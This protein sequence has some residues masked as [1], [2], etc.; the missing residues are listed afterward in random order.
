M[1]KRIF[2]KLILTLIGLFIVAALGVDYFVTRMAETN[3]RRGLE[4]GL[5]EQARLAV[6]VLR[7][8]PAESSPEVVGE[9]AEAAGARLTLIRSDGAVVADSE[10]DPAT[11]ENHATR[12]EFAAALAGGVGISARFSSTVGTEFLYVA[13]P[14][15]DG[16]LRLALPLSEIRTQTREIRGRIL[17]V[18]LLAFMP[19]VFLA[20]WLAQ[21]L[22]ARLSQIMSFSRDLA[23]GDFQA[24]VPAFSGGE[25]GELSL[26]LQTTADR[27][28][29]MFEQLQEERS[30]FAAAVNGIGAGVLVMDRERRTIV[31]NP[32]MRRMFPNENLGVGDRPFTA[33]HRDIARLF[34]G[35]F[36]QGTSDSVDLSVSEPVKRTWKVSCAPIGGAAGQAQAAVAVFYDITELEETERV[37][38]D[39]VTNVSHELRTPLA[40]IQ[41]YAETLLD[42]AV[43]DPE[44]NRRFLQIIRQNAERLAQ[45][46]S[47]LMALSQIEIRA[48]N[49]DFAPVAVNNLLTQ[50]SDSIRTLTDKKGVAVR[51]E[52]LPVSTEVE[53]D[54][55]S[56]HQV[57]MNLLENAANY[58]PQ[59]GAITLGARREDDEVEFYVRD[60]GVGV[61]SQ[62]IPR[63]FERFYRVDKARSRELGGTG[64]GLA[65]VKHL[66]LAHEG[67][68]RVESEVGR[69]STFYVRIPLQRSRRAVAMDAVSGAVD[70]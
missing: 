26:T 45:L 70:K 63:L 47:D 51:V 60:S 41:G 32:A 67:S 37:R 33:S 22:S 40:S 5:K 9:I 49:Y 54:S 48:R 6:A 53:C 21:R 20:F 64:L 34:D 12:P 23:R 19:A 57:L 4:D 55:D 24:P 62:H 16:A 10:A 30:R 38:R 28:R 29:S 65:I 11:M 18:T 31:C 43:D 35:V 50:A 66:V 1:T 68:V 3:L 2:L 8:R 14:S 61:A 58:T 13:I 59:G 42:G 36:M 7:G 39:F 46:S 17:G 44:H 15:E 52:G 27:L 69:G 56:L 25:L